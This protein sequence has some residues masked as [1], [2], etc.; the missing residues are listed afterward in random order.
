MRKKKKPDGTAMNS[1]LIVRPI[2]KFSWLFILP[3]FVCFCIGF[4]WPFIQGIYL[5]FCNFNIPKDAQWVG[6]ANYAKVFKDAGFINAFW[7]TAAF[8]VVT[9]IVI[10]VFASPWPTP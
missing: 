2:R 1:Q 3:V 10:N 6:L 4:V 8:A 9:I 5:S 7:N